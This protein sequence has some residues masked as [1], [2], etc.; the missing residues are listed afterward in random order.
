MTKRKVLSSNM[1][2][3]PL[4]FGFLGIGYKSPITVNDCVKILPATEVHSALSEKSVGFPNSRTAIKQKAKGSVPS[5]NVL[6]FSHTD[7]YSL[8]CHGKSTFWIHLRYN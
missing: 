6:T 8:L 7:K 5:Y 3:T 1:A 4:S 2:A